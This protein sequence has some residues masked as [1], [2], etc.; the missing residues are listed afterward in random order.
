LVAKGVLDRQMRAPAHESCKVLKQVDVA[1]MGRAGQVRAHVLVRL[2]Q[3]DAGDTVVAEPDIIQAEHCRRCDAQAGEEE[4]AAALRG[5]RGSGAA[6][7]MH[8]YAD[9]R[10]APRAAALLYLFE[11]V[12]LAS[13]QDGRGAVADDDWLM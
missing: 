1:R 11:K 12:L 9:V 7:A 10:K 4:G 2:R 13:V 5:F 6:L 8:P 3:I